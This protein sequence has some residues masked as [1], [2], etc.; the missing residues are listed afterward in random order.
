MSW[1]I[2]NIYLPG[3]PLTSLGDPHI[4]AQ[5]RY[6][7]ELSRYLG[8][9]GLKIDIYCRWEDDQQ[10]NLEIFSR[11]TR[12]I[13]IPVG[14]PEV[15]QKESYIPY[16]KE[17]ATWVPEFQIKHGLH[18]SLVHTYTYLSGPIGIHLKDTWGIPFVHTF[19][20]LG[21]VE[22]EI[23]GPT[24][25]TPKTQQK[26]EKLICSKAD[27]IIAVNEQEK[28]DLIELYQVDPNIISVIN[29]GVNLDNYQPLPQSD[30]R[31]EIAFPND[32]FLITYVGRLDEQWGLKTLLEALHLVDNPMIQAVIVGGPPT[33][34]PFLSR[35]ELSEDPYQ[36]Y[37]DMI[38]GFG[39]ERQVTFVGSKSEELLTKYFSAADVTVLPPFYEPCGI[40][41][42]KALACG[43]SVIASRIGGLKTIVQENRVGVLFEAGNAEQL[44][45]KIK[46]LYDQPKIN[47]ELRKNARP[48]AEEHFNLLTIARAVG[49]VYGNL[50][51]ES[52]QED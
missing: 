28:I 26:I 3:D 42:I 13:R 2:S 52:T 7:N 33:E 11:G 25:Q 36:V 1:E 37:L 16:L 43:S 15:I 49:S 50:I 24:F 47:E 21:A 51:E 45:E 48:Y 6:I 32:V 8:A 20:T 23:L 40:S 4:G 39:L 17:I 22:E 19:H 12:V 9:L 35:P 14:P 29:C 30:S 5:I 18:Y 10:P 46:I 41:A 38:D 27:H 44:A 31:Q 34:K